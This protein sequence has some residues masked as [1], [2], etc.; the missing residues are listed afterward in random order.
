MADIFDFMRILNALLNK[1]VYFNEKKKVFPL[2]YRYTTTF[3][4]YYYFFVKI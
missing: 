4:Y 2:I 1:S 3:Y